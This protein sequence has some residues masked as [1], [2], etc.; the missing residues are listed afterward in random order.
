MYLHVTPSNFPSRI[1]RREALV[2]NPYFFS[3][4]T[5]FMEIFRHRFSNTVILTRS[6]TRQDGFQNP[7]KVYLGRPKLEFGSCHEK[8]DV[9]PYLLYQRRCRV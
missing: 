3:A 4:D 2:Y 7:D 5:R 8:I 9:W 1:V 6:P